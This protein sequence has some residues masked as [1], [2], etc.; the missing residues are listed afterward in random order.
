MLLYYS[1]RGSLPL[2]KMGDRLQVHRTSV[3]NII[4]GLER[5][6]FV[7]REPHERDRR[8]TFG[9]DLHARAR[10]GGRGDRGA[11]RA[12]LRHRAA[13]ARRTWTR[14]RRSSSACART[15]TGSRRRRHAT[16]A[17]NEAT[18]IMTGVARLS[19]VYRQKLVRNKVLRDNPVFAAILQSFEPRSLVNSPMLT[20]G[21]SQSPGTPVGA[22]RVLG[23]I[24]DGE[25]VTRADIARRTGLAR[26]TVAQ[27]VEALMAHRFVYEAGGTA[28]TGGRPPTVL[29]FNRAAGVVLVAALGATHARLAVT[30]LAGDPLAEQRL[31]DRHR[32]RSRADPLSGSTNAS[33]TCCARSIAR[34]TTSAA[35]ASASPRRSRSRAARRSRRR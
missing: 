30:D 15:P 21:E 16:P 33:T 27:R 6:S 11:Q 19:P 35:S 2:G 7:R 22:G 24:R 28:S 23:L 18:T 4:D 9:H 14:S 20:A 25:A 26:S 10:G 32:S 13:A 17:A 1:R 12:A 34:A 31:R 5:S 8:T 29:A 3:T